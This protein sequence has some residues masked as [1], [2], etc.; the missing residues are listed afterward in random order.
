MKF[1]QHG[2]ILIPVIVICF[3]SVKFLLCEQ[4]NS[5]VLRKKDHL[6]K[7]LKNLCYVLIIVFFSLKIACTFYDES[8]TFKNDEGYGVFEKHKSFY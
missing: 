4:F 3:S 2:K 6:I 5:Q 1:S 7:S 8:F